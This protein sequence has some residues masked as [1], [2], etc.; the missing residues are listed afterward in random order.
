MCG[1]GA[2]HDGLGDHAAQGAHPDTAALEDDAGTLARNQLRLLGPQG[3]ALS[4]P[5]TGLEGLGGGRR[6]RGRRRLRP[7]ERRRR[8]RRMSHIVLINN[9]SVDVSV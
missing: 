1:G 7:R 5:G 4:D 8:R 2:H 3:E 6:R 9:S